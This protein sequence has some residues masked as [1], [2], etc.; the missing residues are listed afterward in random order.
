MKIVSSKDNIIF[1]KA[2]SQYELCSTFWRL[3]EYYESPKFRNKFFGIEEYMDWYAA[4]YGNFTYMVDWNGFNVP[5]NI[6]SKFFST[7]PG[8]LFN[9]ERRLFDLLLPWIDSKEKFY[10]IGVHEMDNTLD[11]EYSHAFYYL[12]PKYKKKQ[13]ANI[14]RLDQPFRLRITK[15][16]EKKGYHPSVTDDEIIAWLST[17]TMADSVHYWGGGNIPWDTI[18]PFQVDFYK[19]Y[20]K[21]KKEDEK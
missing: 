3:Q 7:Y 1:L 6:V 12:D 11:H 14:G 5:G 9:K 15:W 8:K 2:E 17:N 16:L 13:T 21:F 10:I 19:R 20:S 18:A 4:E